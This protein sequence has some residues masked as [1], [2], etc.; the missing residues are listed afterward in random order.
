L[1]DDYQSYSVR[2]INPNLGWVIS[3]DN[4]F[5]NSDLRCTTN[6]GDDWNGQFSTSNK[7]LLELSISDQLNGWAVGTDG[8][9]LHTVNGGGILPT[10]PKLI[11]PINNQLV[12]ADSI[13]FKWSFCVPNTTNYSLNISKDSLFINYTDTLISDT[14][15][16]MKN[17][18]P[19]K[20]Y[21]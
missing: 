4:W 12:S 10:I 16:Y 6:G 7:I 9:V 3:K 1:L 19:N 8:L 5:Y 18:E 21:Y 13:T 14:S 20:N 2:F 11:Y 17:L 15:L